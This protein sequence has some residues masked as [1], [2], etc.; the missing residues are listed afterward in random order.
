M[1]VSKKPAGVVS[2]NKT[3]EPRDL[4]AVPRFSTKEVADA[5][6]VPPET[7]RTWFKRKILTIDG[8]RDF[9]IAPK[10]I[11]HGREFSG[12]TVII[13]AI[14]G[15]LTGTAA[16]VNKGGITA[17]AARDAAY[18]FAFGLVDDD[19]EPG[20][21]YPN[22][23]TLLLVPKDGHEGWKGKVVNVGASAATETWRDLF[24]E[25]NSQASQ[26]EILRMDGLWQGAF[27]RLGV[28]SEFEG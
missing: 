5:S 16:G 14:M 13:V 8:D 20:K 10:G 17:E 12:Y 11:G 26:I 7:I 6:L 1:P 9:G 24:N 25:F 22:G 18:Q 28:R 4:M 23:E 19:R 2:V 21:L 15:R 3:K 27:S